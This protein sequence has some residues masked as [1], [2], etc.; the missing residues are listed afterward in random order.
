M[1]RRELSLDMF[2]ICLAR[3]I[4]FLYPNNC[5]DEDDYIQAG[6]LKLAEI[7]S[8][9]YKKHDWQAYTIFAIAR[10]MR[11]SA[12]EAMC[13]IYAPERIKRRVHKIELLLAVSKTEKEICEELE[14]DSK[15]FD[16][17][18]S[19]IVTESWQRL[20][21]E[22][23]YNAEPFSVFDDILSSCCLTEADKT[24][25]QAQFEDDINSL[26]LTSKQRWLQMKNLRPKLTRSGYG[27]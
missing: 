3:K 21:D 26:G 13:A 27:N 25:L 24:F 9:R 17:L 22:P 1:K 19:L 2:I 12:L 6:Y 23:T 4:A 7:N 10:A 5:A 11:E 20:F 15:T 8:G 14:I 18:K 16:N